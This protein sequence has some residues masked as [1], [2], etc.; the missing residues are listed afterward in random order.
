MLKKSIVLLLLSVLL[1]TLY[2][3]NNSIVQAAGFEQFPDIG[4]ANVT[5]CLMDMGNI[6]NCFDGDLDTFVRSAKVNP[7]WIQI[8]FPSKIEVYKIKVSLGQPGYYDIVHNWWLESADSLN[9]LNNKT[10]SY[11]IVVPERATSV[12][13]V[14]DELKLTQPVKGRI[15]K[16]NIKETLGDGNVYIPELQLISY[17]YGVKLDVLSFLKTGSVDVNTNKSGSGDVSKCFD[18]DTSSYYKLGRS[19]PLIVD[20][21]EPRL[22]INR[23][24]FFTAQDKGSGEKD[25]LIIEAA[26]STQDLESRTKSYKLVDEKE[27]DSNSWNDIYINSPVNKRYWAF[28]V[29]SAHSADPINI[30]E[31]EFWADQRFYEYMPPTPTNLELLERTESAATLKWHPSIDSTGLVIYQI[32]R[33][34]L[35]VA[36]TKEARYKDNNLNSDRAYTYFIKAYNISRKYSEQSTVVM[37]PPFSS[38]IPASDS[39]SD[40][41][42]NMILPTKVI[43]TP[44]TSPGS[45][46]ATAS[47]DNTP[48]PSPLQSESVKSTSGASE[49]NDNSVFPGSSPDRNREKEK[50]EDAFPAYVIILSVIVIILFLTWLILMIFK[51]KKK[52]RISQKKRETELNAIKQLLIEEKTEHVIELLGKKGKYDKR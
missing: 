49:K 7:A 3:C 45:A 38:G 36:T 20:F 15:W 30:S 37:V 8:E 50:T 46:T 44:S 6:M 33:D 16:F 5:S 25:K 10:G 24:R 9:D 40:H 31:I 22:I 47:P 29:K 35:L 23:L 18:G 51:L 11:K 28:T 1:F 14:W 32:Y 48:V 4:N 19:S 43:P 13:N 52:M 26:D 17:Y 39:N 27:I 34:G 2:I 21:K 41:P 42:A 12:D